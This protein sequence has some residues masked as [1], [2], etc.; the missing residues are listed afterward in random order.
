MNSS[1]LAAI[2]IVGMMLSTWLVS[3]AIR[4]ASIVDIT[5]GLGFALVAAVLWVSKGSS[6][7]LVVL[8]SLMA[9][10]WGLRL[11]AY[12]GW[13]NIGH[14][15]DFRYRAMRK[16]WG[17]RFGLISLGTVFAFQGLIMW[18][19]SLPVHLVHGSD[20]PGLGVVA[21]VGVV[22]WMVGMVFETVG[23]FQLARFKSDPANEGKVM[24]SG[25][26]RYTRHPNYFGNACIWWGIAIAAS[27][28][29]DA[30]WGLIGAAL[31]NLLLVRVSG[32]ALLE[33]SLKRR[34]PDYEAYIARTSSFI[35]RPPRG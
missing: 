24:E 5:W 21:L 7:S 11:T 16:R 29:P 18:V 8:V 15:E 3:L 28:F 6:N 27:T 26:W 4:N 19:V 12:L 14:G 17:S 23:D 2:V 32:V 9:I 35:P 31:M 30:R 20:D 13:R 33:K 34:K 10:A 22:L 1:L 25:L